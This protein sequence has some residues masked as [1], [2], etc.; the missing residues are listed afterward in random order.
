MKWNCREER[1]EERGICAGSAVVL[2]AALEIPEAVEVV[3]A[4]IPAEGVGEVGEIGKEEPLVRLPRLASHAPADSP[5]SV[6]AAL[7]AVVPVRGLRRP[8]LPL[9]PLLASLAAIL[10]AVRALGG[11]SLRLIG[12][13]GARGPGASGRTGA[14]AEQGA[15]LTQGAEGARA[16]TG[17]VCGRR[18]DQG[19]RGAGSCWIPADGGAA[20]SAA[21]LDASALR[22][23]LALGDARGGLGEP[24]KP[25]LSVVDEGAGAWLSS[26]E[27]GRP[28]NR[29]TWKSTG[30]TYEAALLTRKATGLAWKASKRRGERRWPEAARL[31][32]AAALS[33]TGLA[34]AACLDRISGRAALAWVEDAQEVREE[35]CLPL[36]A[37]GGI[38]GR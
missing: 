27:A 29:S 13:E 38:S 32:E 28:D 15:K 11:R 20:D 8:L 24:V 16:E 31:Y 14:Q 26:G 25:R 37:G 30:L 1:L 5:S 9:P 21:L 10:P 33:V 7:P 17:F 18:D 35:P 2:D 22:V 36:R 4:L 3:E 12:G 19:G 34:A 23:A 6:Q